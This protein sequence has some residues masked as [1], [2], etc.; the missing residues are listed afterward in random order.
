VTARFEAIGAERTARV[1]RISPALDL[2]TRTFE[3]IARIDNPDGALKSG[4][5]AVIQLGKGKAKA[6]ETGGAASAAGEG[7]KKASAGAAA[8]KAE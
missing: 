8:G 6:A 3:V 2:R 5:L 7:A 1:H 4:M